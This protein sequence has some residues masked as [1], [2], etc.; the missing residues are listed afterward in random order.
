MLNQTEHQPRRVELSL[1]D[2]YAT[3]AW[4]Y[5]PAASDDMRCPV[6]YVHGIQSHPGWFVRSCDALARA[7]HPV[8]AVARRGSGENAVARGHARSVGQ[9]VDDL[10]AAVTW[11]CMRFYGVSQV[12]LVGV[13]WGGKLAA[14]YCLESAYASRVVSLTMVA[15]GTVPRVD[16]SW[17]TKFAVAAALLYRPKKLFDIPLSDVELFTDNEAMRAFLRADPHRLMRATAR[18]LFAS[19]ELDWRL[20][21]ARAGRLA[22]PTALLLAARDRIIDNAATESAVRRLAPLARVVTLDA[23]HTMDFEEVPA[24]FLAALTAA[25]GEAE[26]H[27]AP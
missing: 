7:G 23:A 19:R 22:M 17:R 20:S 16:V 3:Y 4:L 14:A 15:P 26:N 6:V 9:L 11:V 25:C 24:D 10:D 2:G 13:S 18:F 27:L 5:A 1:R 12:H 21:R 8:L